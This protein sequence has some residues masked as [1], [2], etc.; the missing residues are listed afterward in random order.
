MAA[1]A[2]IKAL[3]ILRLFGGVLFDSVSYAMGLTNI[4]FKIYF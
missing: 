2:G 1:V 4:S 3:A